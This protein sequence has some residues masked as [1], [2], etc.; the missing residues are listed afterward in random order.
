MVGVAESCTPL[1][2]QQRLIREGI[3]TERKALQDKT[4][5]PPAANL[6]PKVLY[7]VII[8]AFPAI[9]HLIISLNLDDKCYEGHLLR[10]TDGSVLLNPNL[11]L[12]DLVALI[13]PAAGPRSSRRSHRS[14]F[15]S[16]EPSLLSR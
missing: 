7:A 8:T 5:I 10:K 16:L 12:R 11:G 13:V 2:E 3:V 1:V 9:A 6:K 14:S 15:A 4:Q